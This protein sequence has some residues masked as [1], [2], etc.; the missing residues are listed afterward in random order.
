ML[1]FQ[2]KGTAEPLPGDCTATAWQRNQRGGASVGQQESPHWR[3]ERAA[4]EGTEERRHCSLPRASQ[5]TPVPVLLPPASGRAMILPG[6]VER[7]GAP[8]LPGVA[9]AL[10]F[11]GPP[12]GP[13][14][15]C[16]SVR[17]RAL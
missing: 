7:G 11:T 16:W 15:E 3:E 1:D 5:E 13:G 6:G 9:A 17:A 14:S 2:H 10:S 4:G 12:T 8:R